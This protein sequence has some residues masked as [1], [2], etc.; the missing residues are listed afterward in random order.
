MVLTFGVYVGTSTVTGLLEAGLSTVVELKKL[1][2]EF[3]VAGEDRICESISWEL[4]NVSSCDWFC[5][6]TLL[7][8][9]KTPSTSMSLNGSSPLLLK[10]SDSVLFGFA[11]L[12]TDKF[13][14]FETFD[15]FE[16]SAAM[17][18]IGALACQKDSYLRSLATKVVSCNQQG[19]RYQVELEDTVLFP[20]GGGQP[21]DTGRILVGE[22]SL[23]VESV[24]R[25][26]LKALHIVDKPLELGTTVNLN[27]NWEKRF[28]HMQQ[29]T[30]Q[31]LLSAILD[32]RDLPTLGWNMGEMINYVE[33]PRKLT[34]SE[35]VEVANEVNSKITANL[36]ITVEVPPDREVDS[37]KGVMRIIHIGDLDANACCGTHL[38][39][40]GQIKGI[41]LL[42]QVS[43]KG[44]NSRLNFIAG[45]RIFRYTE[46]SH[47]ILRSLSSSTSVQAEQLVDKVNALVVSSKKLQSRESALLKELATRTAEELKQTLSEGKTV[48]FHRPDVGLDF[49]NQMFKELKDSPGTVVLLSGE[50][51][52]GGAAIVFGENTTEVSAKLKELLTGLKGGGKGKFQGK[53]ASYGKG[54]LEKVKQQWT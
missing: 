53:V 47:E 14:T 2:S 7:I 23:D 50:G 19:N 12:S 38:K 42:N 6:W 8:S 11:S 30:G 33:L 32:K 46:S 43:G 29:H 31:H 16:K 51:K 44:S 9:D 25:S 28:D 48:V 40:A 41:V 5:W 13:E 26:G 10:N 3:L 52:D 21:S 20:E 4:R 22:Q 45:D 1:D 24:I 34:D 37:V 35:K 15:T 36:P 49:L 39:S 18:I 54:E 27:V 17:S